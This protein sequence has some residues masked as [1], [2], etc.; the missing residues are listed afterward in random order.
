MKKLKVGI[1]GA[2]SLSISHMEAYRSNPAVEIIAV[3]DKSIDRAMQRAA[4]YG[5]KAYYGDYI[6]LLEN[7]E[8]D[9]VS[10]ITSNNTHAKISIAALEAGKH[11]LCEKPPALDATGAMAMEEAAL[12]MGKL[13]MFG[14][15]RRFAENAQLLKASIKNG[16]LGE[17]YYVKTGL[18]RRC[19][20]PGGWFANK[21]IS[22]GGPLIDVGVHIMDLAV[23]LMGQPKPVE[24]LG[25]VSSKLGSRG[26]I[27]GTSWYKAADF[28]TGR[29][30]VED[31]ASALI[32]FDNGA[33]LFVET[34]W[35]MY[36]KEDTSYMDIFGTKGGARLEPSLEIYSELDDFM[37]DITPVLDNSGL[38][39]KQAFQAELDHFTNCIING[40]ECICP[41]K[42]GTAIMKM[43]DAVYKS[44][45]MGKSISLV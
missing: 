20:N 21:E 9:A 29:N 42:D 33:S 37:V 23:Y 38:N 5:V 24:V 22:G 28:D 1:I 40:L 27:K 12:K 15:V 30:T 31:F 34:S 11:V 44:A 41:A 14:F 16:T 4:E 36:I 17:I 19:G 35:A 45:E 2:G 7:T 26:N 25:T 39:V 8:I 18:L 3:C 32:K 13:L 6:E 10:V 43:I